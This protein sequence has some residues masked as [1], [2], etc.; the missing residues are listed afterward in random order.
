MWTETTTSVPFPDTVSPPEAPGLPAIPEIPG[1]LTNG[2]VSSPVGRAARRR[3]RVRSRRQLSSAMLACVGIPTLVL[4]LLWRNLTEPFWYNEQWRAYYVSAGGN[5]WATVKTD[6]APFSAGWYFLERFS[7]EIFGSTELALRLPVAFFLPISCLLLML[8][9]RRWISTPA[10]TIVAVVGSLTGTLVSF[11][12]QLSEYQID[13]A[14][15]ISIVL[16]YEIARDV[17]PA[18]LRSTRTYLCYGGIALACVFSTPAVFV[19][20]P[21]SFSMSSGPDDDGMSM[22]TRWAQSERESSRWHTSVS[23]SSLKARPS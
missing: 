13:A 3:R 5:W 4:L 19:A 21:F 9:A 1:I 8:L 7:G 6:G 16:L 22:H 10:A 12:V 18:P 11:A 15:V 14:A 23:S 17:D 20:A 2:P